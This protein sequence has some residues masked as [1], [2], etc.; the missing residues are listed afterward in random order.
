MFHRTMSRSESACGAA[1]DSSVTLTPRSAR[2][3]SAFYSAI[4]RCSA[5]SFLL[6]C[7]AFTAFSQEAT[8]VGSVTDPSG[9]VVPNVKVVATNTGKNQSVDVMSNDSGQFIF[10]SLGIGRYNVHAEISGFKSFDQNDIVLQ[11][12]DRTRVD[13]K[14]Q[15]GNTKDSVTVEAEA[16]A[17]KSESGEVSNVI[18][19][20][21][22]SQLATN[23]RSIYALTTLVPGASG[24]MSDLNIP[25]PLAGDASVSFNGM[26]E[27]HNLYL[28]DGGEAADRGGAGGI[29]VMPSMDAVAEFRTNTSNYGAEYGLSSSA[30]MT[31]EIK[32]GQKDLH[33]SAWEFVRNDA[34]QAGNFFTNAAGAKT[35]ELRQNTYG[36]NVSG[37]VTLGKLYNKQRD[38]T[39]FFY[40][41][42]KRSL[43][44]GGLVNQTVPPV[45]EYGGQFSSPINV[46]TGI[47]PA[48]GNLTGLGA[49]F[50][51][52]KI[53]T[54]LLNPNSLALLGA[55]I[56]PAPND[57]N[58]FLGGN[59]LPTSL[60]ENIIRIDHRFSDKFS[61]F[62][63]FLHE[64]SSQTYGTTQ[65]SSDNVP[66][67]GDTLTNPAYHAVIHA[68]YSI[69]PT[70]LNEIAYNQNGNTINI[71]PTG[72]FARPSG[73][74][75]PELF[76]GNNLNRIP[77]IQL[78]GSTGTFYD[79][80]AWPWHNK[81]DDYQIRDDLSIVKGSHQIKLGGSYAIYSKTQDLFGDT[82]GS[83]KFDGSFTGNDFADFLLGY[84]KSYTELAVQDHGV[85]KNNS[86][87]LYIQDNWHVNSR[88]TV[89]LGLRWDGIPHTYE[90]N[91]RQS[92]FYPQ[93]YNQA[94]APIFLAGS[95]NNAISPNSPGLGGSPNPILSAAGTQ[96]YLNG[97]GV[98]GQN[99]I[100]KGLVK[101]AWRNFGPRV[102]F[103]YDVAGD[104]KTVLRGGF[105]AMYERIQG[106][107]VYN[108]GPNEPFSSSVTF[109]NVSINNP[110][111]SL[112]TGQ[113]LSA[114][115]TVG[116]IT[117]LSYTDYKPPVSYQYSIGVERQLA[118]NSVLNV[119]YVGNQN[120]HQND[121]RNID[122]PNQNQLAGLITNNAAY[123]TLLPYQGFSSIS[124]AENAGNGHYNGLQISL[125]S[126]I[127]RNLSLNVAYTYSSAI[128]PTNGGD[129]YTVSNPYNRSYDNGPSPY[130]RSN[131]LVVNFIYDLPFFRST[132]NHLLHTTLGG[133]E[134]AAI[135]TMQSG[136]PLLLSLSGNQSNNGVSGGTN[137]PDLTGAVTYPGNVSTFFSGNFSNPALGAWGDMGKGTVRGPGRDNWNISLFKN[138]AISERR[139]SRFELR[140]ET[141]NSFNHTEFRN[142]G[143]QLGNN[144]FGQVTSTWDPRTFQL[145]AKLIF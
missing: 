116:S 55:G 34:L 121:Y 19:N 143:T 95:G 109:N 125:A 145:G 137:R 74:S 81:A 29:D 85:W 90:A 89:N 138:F 2:I 77:G 106:N 134:V 130:D 31:L 11:V 98:A 124:L 14:L 105:G 66:T 72:L 83:F 93:L 70:I 96:F 25:T 51:G 64:S 68:T 75:S 86:P 7:F 4:G 48:I 122:V 118:A 24:N 33:A 88:L 54:S 1:P 32:S 110:A 3:A 101:D 126:Q 100:P 140:V 52:M 8:I 20:K 40:N 57:G 30:T 107:D 135:G 128:D 133:W 80:Y 59:K 69:T 15:V 108:L 144:Q 36:F 50:P 94:N 21:Q 45:S 42:E 62:G 114:P 18:T 5:L 111:Q 23:G 99:G 141:F 91:N 129:L 139:G 61:I 16:I 76:P 43:I 28:I 120:R 46:P 92:N 103:A 79:V 13:V 37:P 97:I 113:T 63:H 17:V 12:G 9:A 142:V 53:P 60:T 127:K 10:P 38:K 41:W 27:S 26:R 82:Q 49:T 39:F 131:I 22:M 84:A 71:S 115:I 44:Q 73:F 119:S 123:N 102:G 136:L 132:Q 58:A 104:H 65:W 6:A 56:F 67:I 78:G 117:G 112:F 47:S 87:A 35:P